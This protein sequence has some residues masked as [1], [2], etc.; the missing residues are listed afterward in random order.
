MQGG[1]ARDARSLD[2][3]VISIS[4]WTQAM[5]SI[6]YTNALA[7]CWVQVLMT[8]RSDVCR[9][10]FALRSHQVSVPTFSQRGMKLEQRFCTSHIGIAVS[11]PQ[12]LLAANALAHPKSLPMLTRVLV[13]AESVK[14]SLLS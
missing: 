13:G 14:V 7:S 1:N 9:S 12:N 10:Q 5:V 11:N 3:T 4:V 2:G 8:V 6:E